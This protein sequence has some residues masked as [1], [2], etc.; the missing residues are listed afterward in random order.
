[1]VNIPTSVISWWISSFVN[2]DPHVSSEQWT[3]ISWPP[4]NLCVWL[5]GSTKLNMSRTTLSVAPA[6]FLCFYP[7]SF[8]LVKNLKIILNPFLY[9][10]SYDQLLS[11]LLLKYLIFPLF[12][13]SSITSSTQNPI[14]FSMDKKLIVPNI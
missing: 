14:I 9:L 5:S 13:I 1:M 8:V 3:D 7:T 12:S 2:C 4:A 11:I 6:H 10:I